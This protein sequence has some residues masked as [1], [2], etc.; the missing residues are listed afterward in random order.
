LPLYFRPI[1]IPPLNILILIVGS[2]GDVQPFVALGQELLKYGH[3]VRL[4][5]HETFRQ[6]VHDGGL[7]FYPLAGDPTELMAYMVKNPGLLPGLSSIR[8]GEIG[9][10]RETIRDILESSW[11][12]AIAPDDETGQYFMADSIIANPPSFGHVHVAQKLLVPLHI[13]FTMPWSRTKAFPHPLANVSYKNAASG[14]VNR[15]SYDVIDTLTWEGL[16]DVINK[17]RKKTLGLKPLS[18]YDGAYALRH[19]KVPHTYTWSPGL[20]PKPQDWKNHI[21]VCGF[22]FLDLASQ[23]TPPDD[24]VAFLAAG[25][26]PVYIGFGSIVVDDPDAMTKMIFD[27]VKEAGVRAI[28]SKGWGGLGGG[29]VPDT[30]YLIGNCPHDWLF[31][32]VSAVCHHGG[33]GTTAAGLKAGRPTIIVP[34]FGDQPF[35]GSMVANIGVG[36]VPVPFKKLTA[37]RLAKAIKVALSEK[38]VKAAAD[39]GAKMRQENGVVEG[40]KSF[41]RLLPLSDMRCDISPTLKAVLF[42][43]ELNMKFSRKVIGVLMEA[44]LLTPAD[45]HPYRYD[46]W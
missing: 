1:G 35:W 21:E 22:F 10:K 36:P 23:Y 42:S 40:A 2:R 41:H 37:H 25:P 16:G 13:Y 17:F 9:K 28:V 15:L 24:L 11:Q 45:V 46:S 5:T 39:L 32:N 7:E 6:F 20:I 31:Q 14:T 34:F 12:A 29:A 30:I 27:G 33:A 38:V 4:A 18:T 26:P 8:A 43:P 3:R 44:G 19:L